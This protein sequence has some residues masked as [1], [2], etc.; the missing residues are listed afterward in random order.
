MGRMASRNRPRNDA[1]GVIPTPHP[2]SRRARRRVAVAAVAFVAVMASVPTANAATPPSTSVKVKSED[3]WTPTGIDVRA[4]DTITITATGLIHFGQGNIDR[5]R[6][7]GPPPLACTRIKNQV[8]AGRFPVP[9]LPCWSLIGRIGAGPP[10]EIGGR[11]T[12]LAPSAG[13]LSLG[14]NDNN[15]ADNSGAWAATIVVNA[16]PAAAKSTD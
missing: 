2:L 5:V 12:F 10:F 11:K 13:E 9:T 8:G 7:P 1:Y 4:G 6:P 14:V 3:T 15:L 16:G